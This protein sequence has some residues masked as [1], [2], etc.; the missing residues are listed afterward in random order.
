MQFPTATV[1]F[2]IPFSPISSECD[3]FC[4]ML[5]LYVF[6]AVVLQSY[7][8]QSMCMHIIIE[9]ARHACM[10]MNLSMHVSQ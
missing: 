7:Y 9:L 6:F 1:L 10:Y 5:Y 3:G 2:L 4:C 8:V